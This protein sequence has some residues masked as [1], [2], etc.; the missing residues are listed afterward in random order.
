[1]NDIETLAGRERVSALEKI[2]DEVL[3]PRL[4]VEFRRVLQQVP[5]LT[6][7]RVCGDAGRLLWPPHTV[8]IFASDDLRLC[9]PDSRIGGN[10]R[11]KRLFSCLQS[12][13]KFAVSTVQFVERPPRD[14]HAVRQRLI[15][16][17]N[18]NLRLCLKRHIVRN[19]TFFRR[20]MSSAQCSG[21]YKRLSRMV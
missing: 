7:S 10:F 1:M 2:L 17:V 9:R 15:D 6:G 13:Q 18:R 8:M 5:D 21:K 4:K 16:Q 19:V 11:N 12:V 3:L 20:T 14:T